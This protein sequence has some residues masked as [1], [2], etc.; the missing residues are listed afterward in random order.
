M[1]SAA[2]RGDALYTPDFDDM[3]RLATEFSRVRVQA[4]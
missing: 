3:T 2:Q 1:A 4:V